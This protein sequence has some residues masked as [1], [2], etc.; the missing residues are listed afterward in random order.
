MRLPVVLAA[1]SERFADAAFFFEA[2]VPLLA[3]EDADATRVV[4]ELRIVEALARGEIVGSHRSQTILL[5]RER[6]F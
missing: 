5:W 2:P 6:L 1:V 3:E 4:L